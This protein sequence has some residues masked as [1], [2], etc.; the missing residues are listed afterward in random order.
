MPWASKRPC[1]G[2][3]GHCFNLSEKDGL[4][5][6]CLKDRERERRRTETW[7][8]VRGPR[9]GTVDIYQ[10]PE[11][12]A[13]SKDYLQQHPLCVTCLAE[14]RTEPSTLV[15]HVIPHRGNMQLFW[16]PE[17]WQAQ[18]ASCHSKKTA[19]EVHERRDGHE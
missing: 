6:A 15:D 10:T 1:R 11:W 13:A 3:G 4:C 2:R 9:G 16:D 8:K 18:C 14:E 5:R 19:K 17:N 12:K 7:R